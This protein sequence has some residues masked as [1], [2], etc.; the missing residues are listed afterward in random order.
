M[1]HQNQPWTMIVLKNAI[2]VP[3]AFVRSVSV[4]KPRP[5]VRLQV[6]HL[7]PVL[8]SLCWIFSFPCRDAGAQV[9]SAGVRA[10]VCEAAAAGSPYVPV[11]HWI[12]PQ[13]LRLY[14]MGYV[15][16]IYL[17]MR[18]W[19]RSSIAGMLEDAN[20]RI[21][22]AEEAG[23]AAAVEAREIYNAVEDAISS[24]AEVACAGS[25]G[26]VQLESVYSAVRA[27]SGTPLRD[28]YH[29]GSTIVNDYGRRYENGLN[30]YSGL[31]GYAVAGPF[32]LYVRGEF[33][34]APSAA[35]YPSSL[36]QVL[37]GP[38]VDQTYNPVTGVAYPNQ[39]TIPAGPLGAVTQGSLLEA[40]VSTQVLNHVISF[41]KQDDWMGPAE[42]ASMAYSNNAE[43]VYA[44]HINRIEPLN[45][46]VL[47]RIT[48][49]FRYEFLIGELQGH[50]LMPN[51]LYNNNPAAQ[52]NVI[53]P[54]NPWVHVE[55]LSF[56]PTENVE[57]GFERTVLFGGEGH[58]PVTLHTFLKS[59][60]STVN[61]PAAEKNSPSD[62]GARFSAFD[63]SYRLPFVRNWLTL[64][65]DS[66]VH[67]D[68]SPIDAPRRAA[69]RPGL[70]LSHVPGLARL[71]VRVEGATTDPPVS[72]SVNG[73]FMYWEGIEKQGYT[74]QGQLFGDWIGREDKGGQAWFTYHLSGNEW[75]QASWRRQKSAKDFVPGGTTLDDFALQV[76]KRIR[77]DLEID[78]NFDFEHW[79]APVYLP[80]EQTVTATTIQLT[81]YP[82]RL[83]RF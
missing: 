23:D 30:N 67:D 60:F 16:G 6:K 50:T 66:E 41:G 72:R 26:A 15:D 5:R 10:P 62:P 7:L 78:G 44:L 39:A 51:P 8:A 4:P 63:F 36:V 57:L 12:Y 76:V 83:N 34:G 17:D 32:T 55:K 75:A 29:L 43:N 40:Y 13:M 38:S 52:G 53:N 1:K 68:V 64:Y 2:E 74:N 70:Y 82:T 25:K 73:T 61:V 27:I 19:T 42:G 9:Q 24:G 28:S 69:I 46:P 49:P 37:A 47:S 20:D 22:D 77:K 35:G 11:D 65:A 33:Q 81:W 56:H 14:A 45:I 54:G 3:F 31:S 71:D 80:G 59:F 18:P 48:G 21:S 58:S 79:K